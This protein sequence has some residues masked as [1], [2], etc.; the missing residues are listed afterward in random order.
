MK[1]IPRA[2]IAIRP[3]DGPINP[4]DNIADVAIAAGIEH[5]AG[6]DSGVRRDASRPGVN[7]VSGDDSRNVAAVAVIIEW[8][9]V[10]ATA[11]T[12]RESSPETA[13]TPGREASRR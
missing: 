2:V 3:I 4:G 1:V 11:A 5:F 12:M 13:L 7:A 9:V 8:I 6:D 10:T